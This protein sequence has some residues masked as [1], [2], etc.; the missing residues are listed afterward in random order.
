M[1]ANSDDEDNTPGFGS[2]RRKRKDYTAPIGFVSG[3]IKQ[4]SKIKKEGEGEEDSSVCVEACVLYYS[5]ICINV[6][7]DVEFSLV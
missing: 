5:A 4:G 1:W 7:D 2:G 6:K 3:G